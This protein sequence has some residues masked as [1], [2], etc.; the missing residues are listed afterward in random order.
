MESP[1]EVKCL[2][3][4]LEENQTNAEG[5][6]SS[7]ESFSENEDIDIMGSQDTRRDF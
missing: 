2:E 1:Q 3:R 5:Q 6:P 7:K 4:K